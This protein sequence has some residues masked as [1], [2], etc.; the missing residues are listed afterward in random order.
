MTSNE[1]IV[2]KYTAEPTLALLHTALDLVRYVSGPFGSGKSSG[3]F[4]DI[5]MRAL[6]Q[7]PDEN[8]VRKSRWAVV[9]NTYPELKSTTIKTY[10]EWVPNAIAPVVYGIPITSNFKQRLNDGTRVELEVVFMALDTDE[11]VKK[12][13]SMEL[14]GAYLNE[15]RELPWS[16]VEGLLGRID[17]YPQTIK[18]ENGVKL[19]G[20][21][22]PGMLMDS[23]PP[24]TT[25]WL[26]EK[27]ETGKTPVG[28]RKF[29]QPPAVYKDME[30]GEWKLNPDAENLSHLSDTYYQKQMDAA[31]DDFIRVNLGG[32]FGMSR[33]G[34]PVFNKYSEH[35]HVAKEK[36]IP[37]RGYPIII[38]MDF[39]LT[40]ASVLMQVTGRGIRIYDELP[41]SDETLE[42]YLDEYLQPL[43]AKKYQGFQVVGSGDPAG[44]QRD[45]HTK[46]N[47]FQILRGRGIKAYPAIT[48]DITQR[49]SCVNWFLGR[50]EGF[51]IDPGCTHLR[52]AMGGGYVFKESKN[53]QGQVLDTPAKNEYSHIAD[54]VQYG[55]L[56]ARFGTR[57]VTPKQVTDT[58]KKPHF[59]A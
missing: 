51:V 28:W 44:N 18:D 57:S 47:D 58:G 3:C 43:L 13:L 40:P 56:Y 22:E 25:H 50:D 24:K 5:V 1:V 17:R 54:A 4:M 59:Y 31:T 41:A 6:R 11:D 19:Y 26:Y 45:R 8:G 35:K 23:N 9:R 20:P 39:G 10:Q 2:K 27:F 15:A 46:T 53:A 16:I 33:K 36:L 42:D 49:I 7:Q 38:G 48:N 37:I 55:C 12:L 34:K 29:Q 52:E 32:E 21:T 30:T 14:T